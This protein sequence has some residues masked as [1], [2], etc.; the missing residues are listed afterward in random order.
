MKSSAVLRSI[1]VV[2]AIAAIAGAVHSAAASVSVAR[3][4]QRRI[5]ILVTPAVANNDVDLGKTKAIDVAIAGEPS[6][7][8]GDIDPQTVEFAG[9]IPAKS[10]TSSK[11][12]DN[13]GEADR[14]YS[15][16]PG[17]LKLTLTDT[18]ACL[19]FETLNKQKMSGCDKVKVIKSGQY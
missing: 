2:T 12:W 5:R 15:F 1:A 10:S 13:D 17:Q 7:S 6:W 18:L 19:R 4:S 11:D 16:A 14:T 8:F 9:A 3:E